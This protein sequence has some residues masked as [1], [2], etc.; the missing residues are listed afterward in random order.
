MQRA[1][2]DFKHNDIK[3][4]MISKTLELSLQT[5]NFAVARQD[6][7]LLE[8]VNRAILETKETKEAVEACKVHY[9]PKNVFLCGL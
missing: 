2:Y 8:D 9:S 5:G 6:S 4:L 7:K 3:G 1:A